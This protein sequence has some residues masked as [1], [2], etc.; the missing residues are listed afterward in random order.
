M[1]PSK[2]VRTMEF[3]T[4]KTPPTFKRRRL[5]LINLRFSDN[6][7][8]AHAQIIWRASALGELSGARQLKRALGQ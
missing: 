2:T 7:V 4:V 8:V 1:P 5:F 3:L 6:L